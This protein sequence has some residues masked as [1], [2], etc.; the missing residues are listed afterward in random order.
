MLELPARLEKA[1]V[2]MYTM[3][4]IHEA[5]FAPRSTMAEPVKTS[6]CRM[7]PRLMQY[8]SEEEFAGVGGLT[9]KLDFEEVHRADS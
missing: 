1:P 3:F 8:H 7:S 9:F 5:I 6:T 2:L 4:G